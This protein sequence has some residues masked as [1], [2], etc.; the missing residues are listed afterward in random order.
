MPKA[1]SVFEYRTNLRSDTDPNYE[2]VARL[3]TGNDPE[4]QAIRLT[5]GTLNVFAGKRTAHRVTP[6]E[7]D[8]ARVVAVFSF[9]D[10]PGVMM[11][12]EEQKGFY[13]RSV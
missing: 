7:G 10:R 2:G 1:G 3:L 13:G 5:P 11:T 9:F 12:A 8:R 4:K 6:A